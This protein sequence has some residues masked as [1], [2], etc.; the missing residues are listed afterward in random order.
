MP[1]FSTASALPVEQL[2]LA[3]VEGEMNVGPLIGDK[4]LGPLPITWRNAAMVGPADAMNESRGRR[5]V[6]SFAVP[7]LPYEAA[8]Q[9]MMTDVGRLV[10]LKYNGSDKERSRASDLLDHRRAG[11]PIHQ[12][13]GCLIDYEVGRLADQHQLGGGAGFQIAQVAGVVLGLQKLTLGQVIEA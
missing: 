7:F 13:A 4:V 12:P 10:D 5:V 2:A 11:F 8:K 6:R 1:A 3:G 9:R